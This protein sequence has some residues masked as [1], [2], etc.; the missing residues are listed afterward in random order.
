M[1]WDE[2]AFLASLTSVAPRT[3]EAYATDLAAFVTW[4]ERGG[5][6]DP[7][8]VDRTLLRRYVAHLTTRRYAKR[9]VA[10]K[11]AALR[12]YFSWGARTGRLPADPAASLSAPRGDG[13]LPRV[14]RQDELNALLED[15]SARG[16]DEPAR[17]RDDAVLE[18][19]YGSGLRVGEL[20]ALD[21]ADLDLDHARAR[22][23][24]KGGKQRQVPLG[25]PSIAALRRW[26]LGPR[27]TWPSNP[28]AVD[29]LFRNQDEWS[30]KAVTNALSMGTFSS[31]RSIREYAD[32]IWG[33]N[34]VI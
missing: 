26:L 9:S 1:A 13:R 20:C 16:V 7:V 19:L 31:D 25:D 29:A 15:P 10:R 6:S 24:G 17:A 23:W 2:G 8:A 33:I 18:L 34:P 22:V 27:T 5:V 4:A 32:K 21:P 12:R 3:R 11:V 28:A 14:L 30:R